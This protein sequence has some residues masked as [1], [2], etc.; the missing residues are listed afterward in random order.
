MNCIRH[1]CQA[2]TDGRLSVGLQGPV[3]NLATSGWQLRPDMTEERPMLEV[4][5]V[6]VHELAFRQRNSAAI[7]GMIPSERQWSRRHHR[8][9]FTRRY[10]GLRPLFPTQWACPALVLEDGR[11]P[12]NVDVQGGRGRPLE[13]VARYLAKYLGKSDDR[14]PGE[15]R[16]R[17]SKGIVIPEETS[18]IEVAAEGN[19]VGA[20]REAMMETDAAVE[21]LA[22]ERERCAGH[23]ALDGR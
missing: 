6:D 17:R 18:E 2:R 3:K 15:R 16:F 14:V 21:M 9:R 13:R 5:A 8:Q 1:A 19:I 4:I 20:V 11:A 12:W 23:S 10:E 7:E 22:F